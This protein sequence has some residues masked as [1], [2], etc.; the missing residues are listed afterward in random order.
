MHHRPGLSEDDVFLAVTTIA[1]DIAG[2]E[3]YLP[4]MIGA[5][6]IL[7]DRETAADGQLLAR[8]MERHNV[9][10]M[11]ATPATWQMLIASGWQGRAQLHILCGGE[12]LPL[13]LARRLLDLG[14]SLWNLY[15]P[16]ET[17]IWS[18]VHAIEKGARSISIGAPLANTQT[19]VLDDDLAPVPVGVP[20]ELF[21]GGDG[22]A[23]GYRNRPGLTAERFVPDPFSGSGGERLYRTGDLMRMSRDGTLIYLGRL[24]HQVKLRGF[25]IE[26]GEVESALA[27]SPGVAQ[28][29]VLLRTDLPTGSGLVAYVILNG[30]GELSQVKPHLRQRLPE[31]MVP[32]HITALEAYPM[33]PNLKIDRAALAR[34]ALPSP[35]SKSTSANTGTFKNQTETLLGGIWSEVLGVPGLGSKS[36]FFDLGGHSLLATRVISRMNRAFSVDVPLRSIFETPVLA[37][38]AILISKHRSRGS[39]RAEGPRPVPR[40][41]SLPLSYPQRQIWLHEQIKDSGHIYHLPFS[42]RM[43]GSLET[44]ALES[45][46]TAVL[47]RHEILRTTFTLEGD[48]PV[49]IINDVSLDLVSV[50]LGNVLDRDREI[51]ADRLLVASHRDPFDLENGPLFRLL[52]LRLAPDHHIILFTVHHLIF[53]GWSRDLLMRELS[54]VYAAVITDRPIRLEEPEIQYADYA[55][56]QRKRLEEGALDDHLAYWKRWL[57]DSDTE[58]VL[59]LDHPRPARMGTQGLTHGFTL[60]LGLGHE[61]RKLS[62]ERGVTLYMTLLT[63]FQILL[64]GYSGRES[65]LIGTPIA[66]RTREETESL[67]GLFVNMLILKAD[68]SGNPTLPDLLGRVRETVLDAFT[69]QELPFDYLISELGVVRQPD[70]TPLS[71]VGFDFQNQPVSRIETSELQLSARG[72]RRNTA[73]TDLILNLQEMGDRLGG[74]IEYNSYLFE[75]STI[76]QMIEDLV[77]VLTKM[78][79]APGRDV[80]SL[81]SGLPRVTAR[82]PRKSSMEL[83]EGSNL[84]LNQLLIWIAQKMATDKPYYNRGIVFRILG[85]VDVHSFEQACATLMRSSDALRTVIEDQDGVPVQRVRDRVSTPFV[86]LDLSD[87]D[88]P[89]KAA[90]N[91]IH[92]QV[93]TPFDMSGTMVLFI[94][95]KT[96][97][98][99][100]TWYLNHHNLIADA[101]SNVLIYGLIANLY[102]R[103]RAGKLPETIDLPQYKD[104]LDY[105]NEYRHSRRYKRVAAYWQ[106]LI[107]E[108]IEEIPFYGRFGRDHVVPSTT[109]H[110]H[111]GEARMRDMERVIKRN[112]PPMGGEDLANLALVSTALY[113]FLYRLS[114]IR[115]LSLGVTLHNRTSKSFAETIGL[116]MQVVPIRVTIGDA[117]TFASLENQVL[118]QILQALKNLPYALKL[119]IKDKPYHALLNYVPGI[120]QPFGDHLVEVERIHTG[121]QD[122]HLAIQVHRFDARRGMVMEFDFDHHV[123]D[124]ASRQQTITHF[125]QILDAYLA[126][127]G[128]TLDR[129]DLMWM[130]AQNAKKQAL[131]EE[132]VLDFDF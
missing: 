120:A 28:A 79:E 129:E 71:Q 45:A 128:T 60:P 34:L 38:L 109:R 49:Q 22:L 23:R 9:T 75:S 16:T 80:A 94:L 29:V 115:R 88:D 84:S 70:R 101:T 68:V 102:A 10:A 1:F 81:L 18:T 50:D 78:A 86:F 42:I 97:E 58:P 107:E 57:E 55:V 96:A 48:E 5:R 65:F 17:T 123:F 41:R 24:D 37:D 105:E 35:V 74:Y 110:V 36:H 125:L 114:G 91:Y 82:R 46:F 13:A 53:D 39:V 52:L 95:I 20:G 111:L 100:F 90:D 93:A 85:S 113:A 63:G 124:E 4:L 106:R 132:I 89:D 127:P 118:R 7:A 8:A 44:V 51:L 121:N 66:G 3:L 25:R 73:K 104:Y 59:P 92:E 112:G 54:S 21:I 47:E 103:A 56:W 43:R 122:E 131:T 126:E 30:E 64:H 116:G 31:Y 33:T 119:N 32:T 72:L 130:E 83:Y 67:I 19:Y 11:Q 77:A 6:L 15:G 108:H 2:L 69:H 12:A 117:E 87:L 98:D 99:R 76:V 27:E 26:L 62:A 14:A 61:L 40:D